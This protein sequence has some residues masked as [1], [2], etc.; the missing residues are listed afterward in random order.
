MT[1]Y[2]E[3]V[4]LYFTANDVTEDKKVPILLSVIGA[5]TY[6]LLRSLLTPTAPKDKSFAD[7]KKELES[8]FEPKPNRAAERYHFRRRRQAPDESIA[9]YVAELHRLTTHC[10]FDGYLED[11]LCD[12]L[13]CGLRVE[14]IRKKLLAEEDL[15]FAKA[16]KLA[17]SCEA[18]ER[19][20]Q[21]LKGADSTV[22][23]INAPRPSRKRAPGGGCYRCGLRN[24]E[25]DKCR[26]KE[27]TCH[28][29]GKKGHIKRACRSKK[30]GKP[31][32]WLDT[33]QQQEGCDD[34]D[35][36]VFYMDQP[37]TRPIRV[38][39]DLNGQPCELEVDT[40]A[41]VS[42]LSEARVNRILPGAQLTQTNVSLRTYTSEKIPVK[43]KLRVKVR[44]GQQEKLL[45]CYVVRGDGPCLMGRDWLK[46]IRLNWREIGVAMLDTTQSRLKSLL[47][48]YGDVFKDELGTMNSIRAELRVKADAS[49]RFHRPRPVP[50]ALKEAVEKEIHRLEAAGILKKVSHCEWAAPIV[51]VP[52]KDGEVRICG[53]YKVTIN[54]ALDV[55]QHPLPRPDDLFATVANGK[56]FSKLDLS[57][58]YQQMLLA[59]GSEKYLTIN[60]HL[61][62]YQYTRLPFGVASAPALFQRAMDIILQGI[63]G[64]ICYID[65]ILI[66]GESD[67]QHLDRVEEV[68]KR[69]AEHG[70][71]VKQK[72]CEFL[73][74]SVEYLGHR[75][76]REGLHTLPSKV[77]AIVDAPEPKNVQELRSFLGLLNYY[78]KF[79]ANLA[80]ILHPLNRLL[81]NDVSWKWS[82]ACACAF[83]KAKQSLVSSQVLAHYNPELPIKM[84]ADAS[85]YGVGAVISHTYPDGSEKPIAFA[86]RTLS[87]SQKN[88][89]QIE[90]EALGLVFGVR[91]FHQ[92]LYGRKFT[93][94]TDHKPLTTIF[95]PKKGI[96]TLAAARLQRWGLVLTAYNYEIEFKPTEKHS[97]ADCLSRLPVEVGKEEAPGDVEVFTVAQVECLPVTA[98]QLGQATRSDPILSKVWQYTRK[99]WPDTVR[100]SLKPYWNRRTELTVEGSCVLWG[101]RV[102]VP[103]KLQ[104][105]V[106]VELHREHP[107][108]VRMKSIARSHMWWPGIDKQLEELVKSCDRCQS[109]KSS[110]APAPLHPWIWPS[111][112]WQRIHI[113][114]AGPFKQKMF[115][116]VVDAHSKWPEVIEMSTTSSGRTIEVL[117]RLFA[118]FGLPEQLVSDNGTQFTSEEFAT[119]TKANGI[120]H[121]RTTP[122]HPSSNGLA[123]RFVQTFKKAMKAGERDGVTLQHQLSNFLLTYRS[124]PHATTNQSPCSL[125]LKREVRTR[126]DLMKPDS[127]GLVTGKQ[128]QQKL[129]HDQKAK[130]REL[131]IGQDVMAR[132][133]RA[134]DKWMPGTVIGRR[135]PLSYTVQMKTG[136][137]WRRHIDQLREHI[138]R[139][140]VNSDPTSSDEVASPSCDFGGSSGD[141]VPENTPVPESGTEDDTRVD[142][143]TEETDE[144]PVVEPVAPQA[145]GSTTRYPTR[146]RKPPDLYGYEPANS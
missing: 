10:K 58:A 144:T 91:R 8:H 97:N 20:A 33:D 63:T 101:I 44:Y 81:R 56:V 69:L 15:T 105:Q 138:D 61:G 49:P 51:P 113:D 123:E 98:Q 43:G 70:L 95:G 96:P 145:S 3:R 117:R 142:A 107:G 55:D 5:K 23:K 6:A 133:Y 16:L 76:D 27:A 48:K 26:F 103:R 19:N 57:Q 79:I 85:A 32:K 24:H 73:K 126:F 34:D 46:H 89:A 68:L 2:L 22:Q 29:C 9:D 131:T 78:S 128:G 116:I 38:E 111:R 50:F 18:A 74:P 130:L 42:I 108:V 59:S 83:R 127:Q 77:S 121:I 60:T 114:Y 39:L 17:L 82:S 13:V 99:G 31:T 36:T 71:R 110:P 124:T 106:L 136:A 4:E 66:S 129:A 119:F 30:G 87:K 141:D 47:Q 45:T 40:G 52:K 125:F 54:G 93:L 21:Q 92:Y 90:K 1:E 134:G 35:L 139:A 132:N 25:A 80:S 122:Y 84:A 112:P 72:K 86:S 41:A 137:I 140:D 104:N 102:I 146:V 115:L 143:P 135:G 120:K 53:D 64:V 109:V 75:I 37:T 94:V 7:I 100:E 28:G 65:D 14:N 118:R 88:Y 12:Q 67:E 62:L 11:E